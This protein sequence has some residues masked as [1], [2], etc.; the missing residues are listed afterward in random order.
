MNSYDVEGIGTIVY[1]EYGEGDQYLFA[2]HGYGMN[3]KQF[4]NLPSYFLSK[5]KV[6]GI[7]LFFHEGSEIKPYSLR[8]IREG[9]AKKD[10]TKLLAPLLQKYEVMDF[11]IANLF[12]CARWNSTQYFFKKYDSQSILE[13]SFL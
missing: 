8:K 11:A 5:Y 13:L 2:F 4:Q 7:N 10:I 1:H 12:V 3:G 6:I 9:L